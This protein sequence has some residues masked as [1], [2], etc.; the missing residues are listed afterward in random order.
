MA[1][2]VIK[3]IRLNR[4]LVYQDDSGTIAA[5]SVVGLSSVS[6]FASQVVIDAGVFGTA[7]SCDSGVSLGDPVRFDS[8]GKAFQALA[9]NYSNVNFIGLCVLKE[10]QTSCHIRLAGKTSAIYSNLVRND[11]YFV[12]LTG[13]VVNTIPGSG[14]FTLRVGTAYDSQSIVIFKGIATKRS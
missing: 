1:F 5:S 10:T 7:V 3:S 4:A 12:G 14:T 6:Y 2:R 9:T 11:D 13:G 8:N